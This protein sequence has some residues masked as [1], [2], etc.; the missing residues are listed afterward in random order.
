[1]TFNQPYQMNQGPAF[2]QIIKRPMTPFERELPINYYKGIQKAARGLGVVCLVL[3]VF[4]TFVLPSILTDPDM[5]DSISITLTIFMLVFGAVALGMAVNT[6]IVRKKVQDAMNDGT[7]IEVTGPAY[8]SSG[9]QKVAMW[10]VGPISLMPMRGSDVMLVQGM[11]TSVIC[12]PRLKAAIAINNQPLRQGV[13]ISFP[14]NL[15]AMAV[16]T[17]FNAM[18]NIGQPQMMPYG[19]YGQAVSLNQPSQQSYPQEYPPPPPSD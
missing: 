1:M 7:A 13:R 10:T 4:S 16:P 14:P 9:R 6:F 19:G 15:E 5:L 12:V 3:F 2:N 11:P 8:M 17:G 18:P